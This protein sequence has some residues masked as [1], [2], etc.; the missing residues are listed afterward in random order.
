MN[1]S[2]RPVFAILLLLAVVL[3]ACR[4]SVK[5]I[6]EVTLGVETSL[7]PAAVWVAEDKGFFQKEGLALNIKEFDS[8]RLSFLA[9]L[10]DGDV[11]I[12]TVAPTPIMFN[13]F[14]RQDFS[15]F[16]T[17]VYSDDDVKVITRKDK[18]IEKAA[19][20]KGKKVGTPAGTTGQFFLAAFLTLNNVP[21]SEVEMIDIQPSDLQLL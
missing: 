21:S 16:A 4:Q 3:P 10:R 9:M 19:D 7:L 2:I 20:L 6:E 12:S 13:S 18:G 8:G 1:A 14:E 17:F 11:D 15:I 5:P